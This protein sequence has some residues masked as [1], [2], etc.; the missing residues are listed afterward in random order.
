WDT[1]IYVF[2]KPTPTINYINSRKAHVF[3]CT[4]QSCHGRSIFVR[5]FLDKGDTKLTSNLCPH[6][7]LCWGEES[8]T[9]AD[10]T[11]DAKATCRALRHRKKFNGSITSVFQCTGKGQVTYSHCQHTKL[12]AWYVF[13]FCISEHT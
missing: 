13:I 12:E 1:P 8:V 3:E 6:T 10:D 7:K 4:A 5:Q 9:A 11:P 2:F